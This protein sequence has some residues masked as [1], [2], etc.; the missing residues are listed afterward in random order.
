M[1]RE[2]HVPAICEFYGIPYS[3]SDPFT[4]SLCLDKARAKETLAFHGIPTARFVVVRDAADTARVPKTLQFPVFVKPIHEGSSKGIT[5]R[6]FCR[7]AAELQSQVAF[8]LEN[9][10]Q[11]VLVE[12]YLPGKEFTCAVLGNGKTAKVLPIVGMN[13][14]SLPSGALPIYGFEAKWIWDR[15][16]NPLQMFDCPAKIDAALARNRASYAR[17][18]PRPR[19]PRLVADRRSPRRAWPAQC[20]RGQS[21]PRNSS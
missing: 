1:N 21:S 19:L 7:T 17:R 14:D 13:F 12:E 10:D 2:A 20:R 8:L 11:P 4:L 6:N 18:V 3:G 5:E 16:E 9:Y 15:P